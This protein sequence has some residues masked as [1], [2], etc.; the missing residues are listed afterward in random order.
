MAI[1]L[2]WLLLVFNALFAYL[3]IGAEWQVQHYAGCASL[4]ACGM[5][6]NQ[7]MH[8]IEKRYS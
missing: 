3:N 1:G 4:F 8:L 6:L 7:L 2:T 5:S